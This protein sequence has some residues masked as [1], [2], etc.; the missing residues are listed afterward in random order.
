MIEGV[1]KAGRIIPVVGVVIDIVATGV[2]IANGESETSSIAGLIG[3]LG[4]GAV[5]G[6]IAVGVGF[7]P[8]GVAI[9][10]TVAA[11]AAGEGATALWEAWIPLD[12]REAIDAGIE[13][14]FEF[15]N[16]ASW[17]VDTL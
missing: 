11:V 3:G 9:V 10:V 14:F 13:D 5:A 16:P 7:P 12:Q 17:F 2:E 4:G 6:G 15:I 1:S 8:I